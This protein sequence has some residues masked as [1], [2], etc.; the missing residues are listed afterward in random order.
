MLELT[1][2]QALR[3]GHE[4]VG[5]EHILLALSE[6]ENGKGVLSELGLRKEKLEEAAV[7]AVEAAA[8]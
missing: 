5:T 1:F 4:Y 7:A 2:R 6:H 3:L 8:S